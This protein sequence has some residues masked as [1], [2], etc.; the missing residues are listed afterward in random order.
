MAQLSSSFVNLT[1]ADSFADPSQFTL[2]LQRKKLVGFL[3]C[4]YFLLRVYDKAFLL[5]SNFFLQKPA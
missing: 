3:L 5:S 2:M 1:L 4:E